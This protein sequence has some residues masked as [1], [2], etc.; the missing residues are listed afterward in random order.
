[1]PITLQPAA[2]SALDLVSLSTAQAALGEVL[3]GDTSVLATLVTAASTAV[4]RYCRRWFNAQT[5]IEIKQPQPGEW[6]KDQADLI[7]LSQYPVIGTPMLRAG[8]AR[9]LAITNT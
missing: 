7:V 5:I 8:W 2:S 6:D 3:P 4:Q 1:M 9:A